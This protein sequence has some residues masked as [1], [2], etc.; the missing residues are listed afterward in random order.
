[1]CVCVCVCVDFEA[2]SRNARDNSICLFMSRSIHRH[3]THARTLCLPGI[4][5]DN[6]RTCARAR[7]DI[8]RDERKKGTVTIAIE[9]RII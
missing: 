4:G 7:G 6:A 8:M 3:D 1:V 5:A 2:V 9:M